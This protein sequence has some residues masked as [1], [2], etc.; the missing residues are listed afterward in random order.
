[1]DEAIVKE[2]AQ[3]HG[4]AIAAGDIATAVADLT[5]AAQ[6]QGPGVMKALPNPLTGATVES[7]E[8]EGDHLVVTI[9]YSGEEDHT[10]VASTWQEIEGKPMIVHLEVR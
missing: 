5:P 2:R 6:G 1:M 7:V 3:K 4:D 10:D 9:R 8:A